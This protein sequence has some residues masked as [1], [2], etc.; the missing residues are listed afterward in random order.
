MLGK[1]HSSPHWCIKYKPSSKNY[2]AFGHSMD[3][4]WIIETL[5]LMSHPGRGGGGADC[6]GVKDEPY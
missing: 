6:L 2:K 3:N 4:E 1:E 5:K